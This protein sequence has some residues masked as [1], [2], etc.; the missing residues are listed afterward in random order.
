MSSTFQSLNY[1]SYQ[2][3]DA[4]AGAEAFSSGYEF[5]GGLSSSGNDQFVS[6]T[7]FNQSDNLGQEFPAKFVD[8]SSQ[9]GFEN[10][11]QST[12][13]YETFSTAGTYG[14]WNWL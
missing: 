2:T 14:F 10:S 3:S 4:T 1:G 12:S 8:L 9:A 7:D 13:G 5:S 6:Y 11:F